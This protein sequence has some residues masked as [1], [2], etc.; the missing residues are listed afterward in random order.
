MAEVAMNMVV[1][2]K[3]ELGIKL[4]ATLFKLHSPSMKARR[5]VRLSGDP[6][7]N[8]ATLSRTCLMMMMWW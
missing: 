8:M 1:Y 3:R 4:V 2:F 7:P 6:L 5:D